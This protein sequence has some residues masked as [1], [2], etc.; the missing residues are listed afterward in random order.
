MVKIHASL[1]YKQD[2]DLIPDEM[3]LKAQIM[4]LTISD[5]L[6]DKVQADLKAADTKAIAKYWR[7]N[8]QTARELGL[9][10]PSQGQPTKDYGQP[11]RDFETRTA[12][13]VQTMANALSDDERAIL[14][15]GAK[16]PS[17]NDT[18]GTVEAA[19]KHL[20]TDKLVNR[21]KN[22]HHDKGLTFDENGLPVLNLEIKE[23]A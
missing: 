12:N 15:S 7:N 18:Y 20:I 2:N 22:G 21:L 11:M 4:D 19:L 14:E 3:T 6:S 8:S 16:S 17:K 5:Y 9:D 13:M 23:E 1:K 10:V